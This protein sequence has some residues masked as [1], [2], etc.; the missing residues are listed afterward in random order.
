MVQS[1]NVEDDVCVGQGC[2]FGYT[3]RSTGV[4]D[5]FTGRVKRVAGD[6]NSPSFQYA[7][8]DRLVPLKEIVILSRGTEF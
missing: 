4:N 1:G 7:E 6:A 8:I 3:G 5:E 2:T